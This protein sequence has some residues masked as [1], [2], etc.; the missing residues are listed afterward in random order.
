MAKSK[1][2]TVKTGFTN[3]PDGLSGDIERDGADLR[4]CDHLGVCDSPKN[5][6]RK[7][8]KDMNKIMVRRAKSDFDKP[9]V[10]FFDVEV[11]SHPN[12]S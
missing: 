10:D 9:T 5:A 7:V 1:E 3:R 6:A 4:W 11:D 2:A 8:R 12:Q